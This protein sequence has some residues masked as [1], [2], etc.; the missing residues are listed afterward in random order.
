MG[1]EKKDGGL[2]GEK[3]M[4]LRGKKDNCIGEIMFLLFNVPDIKLNPV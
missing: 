4:G 3:K 2:G 1:G